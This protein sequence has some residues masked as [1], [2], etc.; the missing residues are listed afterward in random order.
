VNHRAPGVVATPVA[1]HPARGWLATRDLGPPLWDDEVPP[2]ADWVGTL[3]A[4]SR[5][6]AVLAD[7]EDEVL[8]TGVPVFPRDPDAV[9]AWVRGVLEQWRHRPDDDPGRPTPEDVRAVEAGLERIHAAATRLAAS[10]LPD[11]LQHNDLHLGN[12]LRTAAGGYA[13]ID[14]GDALWTHPLT[15]TRIPRWILR[16][17]MGF[18][19]ESEGMAAAE[20]ACLAPWVAHAGAEELRA[21]L[22]DADRVSGLHRAE[23]W[24][25]L[26]ADVPPEVVAEEFRRSVV[27]WLRIAAAEDPYAAATAE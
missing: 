23:S 8:A 12:A 26:Q 2:L 24:R 15:S 17:R 9:V 3:E 18:A 1:V 13:V 21:L 25:R 22:P 14:L 4:W 27:D 10:A 16:H 5:C 19:P 7:H 11:S 6:Q 20:D